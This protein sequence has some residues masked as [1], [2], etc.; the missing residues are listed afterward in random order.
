MLLV[1]FLCVPDWFM[2]K[3]CFI[4]WETSND[5]QP[6]PIPWGFVVVSFLF[7]SEITIS[8]CT[9]LF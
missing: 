6:A 3:G 8:E 1:R 4:N 7:P 5:N 2:Y 9:S